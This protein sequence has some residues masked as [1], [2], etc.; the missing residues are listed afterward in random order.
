MKLIELTPLLSVENRFQ[1]YWNPSETPVS[2]F[3]SVSPSLKPLIYRKIN[4]YIEKFQSSSNFDC[5]LWRGPRSCFA[6]GQLFLTDDEVSP[7][8]ETALAR[9]FE[10]SALRRLETAQLGPMMTGP[11]RTEDRRGLKLQRSY[12]RDREFPRSPEGAKAPRGQ[13]LE[14]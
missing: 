7:L 10:F 9:Q 4:T 3:K 14:R 13:V 6:V 1:Q 8:D 12:H 5:N 11:T 2:S